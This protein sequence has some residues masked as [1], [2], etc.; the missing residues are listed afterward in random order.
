MDESGN[1]ID[2]D[3]IDDVWGVF[4]YLEENTDSFEATVQDSIGD[5]FEKKITE[6]KKK[7]P[8]L[9]TKLTD[10]FMDYYHRYYLRY[11]HYL[12]LI[13]LL[14]Y[15]YLITVWKDVQAG[16]NHPLSAQ[17]RYMKKHQEMTW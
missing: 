17:W 3:E 6:I 10:M 13:T 11:K 9:N 2:D 7:R 1:I 5:Y 12:L 8:S 16:T 14:L 4:E 15:M